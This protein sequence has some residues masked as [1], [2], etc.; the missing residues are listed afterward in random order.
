M[1]GQS[2]EPHFRADPIRLPDGREI[3]VSAFPDGSIAF[4]IG[5]QPYVL[6]DADLS[7]G[8]PTSMAYL[9]VSPGKQGSSASYNYAEWLEGKNGKLHAE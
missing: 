7:R 4:R 3:H 9:R 6:T 1:A 2:H 8:H 5:G